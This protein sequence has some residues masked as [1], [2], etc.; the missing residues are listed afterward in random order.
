MRR[1]SETW[2]SLLEHQGLCS[3]NSAP[4]FS[5]RVVYRG[6]E[7]VSKDFPR[8]RKGQE[9]GVPIEQDHTAWESLFP[10]QLECC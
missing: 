7:I 1:R 3:S 6:Q 5:N 8:W 10:T 2:D 4:T 9:L